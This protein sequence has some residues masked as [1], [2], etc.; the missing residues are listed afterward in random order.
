LGPLWAAEPEHPKSTAEKVFLG[1]KAY[2]TYI[3][4]IYLVIIF[5]ISNFDIYKSLKSQS[6]E[7]YKR[8]VHYYDLDEQ[9][10]GVAALLP[11]HFFQ[12]FVK[13]DII[14]IMECVEKQNERACYSVARRNCIA[15]FPDQTG[16]KYLACMFGKIE[17]STI[18]MQ[19]FCEYHFD[20]DVEEIWT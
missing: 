9:L 7:V 6:L 17:K 11:V 18:P 13:L 12:R 20:D 2:G 10:G 15:R 1:I 3:V 16:N 5:L 14:E 4:F 8:R 19:E